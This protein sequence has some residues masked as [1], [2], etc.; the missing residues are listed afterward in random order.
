[1]AVYALPLI[2]FAFS[3][4]STPPKPTEPVP[5]EPTKPP[6]AAP[7]TPV[8][9]P[10]P[11]EAKAA[12]EKARAEAALFSAESFF[13]DEWKAADASFAAGEKAY[14]VDNAASRT[15]YEAAAKA[16][17]ALSVKSKPLFLEKL[18]KARSDA[19][20]G[21]KQAF[22]LDAQTAVPDDWKTAD[23]FF[24]KGRNQTSSAESGK[25]EAYPDALSSYESASNAFAA[26]IRKALPIFFDARKSDLEKVRAAAVSVGANELSGDRFA[27]ADDASGKALELYK[28][29]DY[30]AAYD[31]WKS[32]RD[33]YIVL[34][35]GSRAYGVKTEI[36]R[37]ALSVYDPSNYSRA[38]DR[39]D[40]AMRFYDDGKVDSSRDAAEESLL[41]FNLAL[42]KGRE[43]YAS[44]RGKA[45]E[46]KRVAARDL[47]AHVAVKA[48]FDAAT[49]IKAEADSSFK[50]EKYDVAANQ[51]SDAEKQFESVRQ[52]AA[53]KRQ[54]AEKAIEAASQRMMESEKTA[55]NADSI[56]EGGAR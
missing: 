38:S 9:V 41:R 48:A 55:K 31:A 47:K 16:F 45:A 14:N 11:A 53:E 12:A 56:I 24:L 3:C 4:A 13:A 15:S 10:A 6:V 34:A 21:R 23:A 26:L 19:E 43:L 44:D 8:P 17:G 18:A 1:L 33:R 36:D 25:L 7:E 28:G 46:A 37:R 51:Y 2:L 39:L 20:K 5:T 29:E 42:A 27:V 52:T 22:D 54:A 30:Y 49:K 32:A 40:V 50:A 35:T